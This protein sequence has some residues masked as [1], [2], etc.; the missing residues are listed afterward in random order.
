M[1]VKNLK[2]DLCWLMLTELLENTCK[3]DLPNFTY[4]RD[5]VNNIKLK[6][7]LGN[8]RPYDPNIFLY[9]IIISKNKNKLEGLNGYYYRLVW[10]LGEI[11]DPKNPR[12]MVPNYSKEIIKAL[13][14][15]SKRDNFKTGFSRGSFIPIE[16]ENKFDIAFATICYLLRSY[17]LIHCRNKNARDFNASKV[18]LNDLFQAHQLGSR[19]YYSNQ[20]NHLAQDYTTQEDYLSEVK[21]GFAIIDKPEDSPYFIWS[22]LT[23][24]ELNRGMIYRHLDY[25]DEANKYF[26]H[27]QLRF[28]RLSIDPYN[29]LTVH[30]DRDKDRYFINP[31]LIKG[32]YERSKVFYEK[33]LFIE[34]LINLLLCLGHILRRSMA[35]TDDRD[36]K[37]YELNLTNLNRAIQFLNVCRRQPVWEIDRILGIFIGYHGRTPF[38]NADDFALAKN[39][40]IDFLRYIPKIFSRI[41]LILIMFIQKHIR[42]K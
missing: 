40:S 2:R 31:A 28:N 25:L 3:K 19:L 24:I 42:P 32:F 29:I 13:G 33:G 4:V 15:E 9:K 38:I 41:S 23:L 16:N 27:F 34:S 30:I 7:N 35:E 22:V 10:I 39:L 5:N 11:I 36:Q 18:A 8:Y 14:K 12:K 6:K 17:S 1:N 20:Y 37:E 26:R 21:K